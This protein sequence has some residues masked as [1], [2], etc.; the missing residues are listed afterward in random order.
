VLSELHTEH[1]DAG[2]VPI[3]ILKDCDSTDEAQEWADA[4]A[5]TAPVHCDGDEA[6]WESFNS[7]ITFP[8][9]PQ[10][11]VIDRDMTVLVNEWD[12]GASELAE[13]AVLGALY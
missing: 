8:A 2:F 12:I 4:F 13:D 6:L 10:A 7:D 1:D 9:K 5:L 11:V 3:T